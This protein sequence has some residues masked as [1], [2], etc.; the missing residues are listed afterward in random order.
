MALVTAAAMTSFASV[1]PAFAAPS[2]AAQYVAFDQC[3]NG[4]SGGT[5][6]SDGWINAPGASDAAGQ[7]YL[8]AH[9]SVGFGRPRVEPAGRDLSLI[10]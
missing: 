4:S 10:G 9:V 2:T 6:C 3:A 7:D 8:C 1:A 5:G